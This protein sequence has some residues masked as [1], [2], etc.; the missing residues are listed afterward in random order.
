[1]MK[2]SITADL[3]TALDTVIME[4]LDDGSFEIIGDVPKWFL[5]FYPNVTS[6]WDKL[7]LG[8]LSFLENFLID[9]EN[10]WIGSNVGPLKSGIWSEFDPLG[11]ECHLEALAVRLENRKILL[12]SLAE[13]AYAEK[14]A[15][16]QKARETN[17][18]YHHLLKEIQK[19][20]IL[21]H[22]IVHDLTGQITGIKYCFELIALQD[23]TPKG[24]EYIENGKKQS[25]K[26]ELL[27][28]DMLNAFSA[29]VESL[30]TF[31][32]D[33]AQVPDILICATEVVNA[34][35]LTFSQNNVNLQLKSDIDL[36]GNWRVVGEKLRLERVVSNL[37]ENAFRYSP[38]Y[39]TVTV[40]L[41][42]DGEFI[43]LTVDD[44][45]SG[46]PQNISKNLFQKFLQ[47]KEKSGRVSL[48]LYFCRVTIER[49]GGSIG[50]L[51]RESSGSRFWFRLPKLVLTKQPS[52]HEDSGV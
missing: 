24:K 17:L 3:F 36:S 16:I 45:G 12:I 21:I 44:E 10:F 11:N 40:D 4:H 23:L 15:L 47:G 34:L 27:I 39:S 41:K 51:P 29:E 38:P 20:E 42:D 46:V 6:D 33:P 28:R 48:G 37:I 50:Y 22:C 43:L 25:K 31:T 9:V 7:K 2:E 19:K 52:I 1:M 32:L 26:Q 8:K 30:N 5:Q 35:L 14:Q 13:I 49:W 18:N